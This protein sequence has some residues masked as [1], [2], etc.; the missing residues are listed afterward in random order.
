MRVLVSTGS[1][2]VGLNP[3]AWFQVGQDITTTVSAGPLAAWDTETLDGL[4][5]L[6]LLVVDQDQQLHTNSLLVTVSNQPPLV[7]VLYPSAGQALTGQGAIAFHRPGREEELELL[8]CSPFAWPWSARIGRHT[9]RVAATDRAGSTAET[10]IVF[11][12][13]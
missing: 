13:K 11:T 1:R 6:Q 12:V 4:Y 2:Q 8:E 3:Q 10:E 9:L 7:K 5:T